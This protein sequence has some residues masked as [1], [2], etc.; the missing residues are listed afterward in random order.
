M[1]EVNILTIQ[2]ILL[3]SFVRNVANHFARFL[4]PRVGAVIFLLDFHL[5]DTFVVGESH[6]VEEHAELVR[7]LRSL[8]GEQNRDVVDFLTLKSGAGDGTEGP[9]GLSL[10]IRLLRDEESAAR[11]VVEPCGLIHLKVS[12]ELLGA[13]QAVH[14][15]LKF[16]PLD[17]LVA[18]H[19][20][21]G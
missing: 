19:D 4:Q 15:V 1:L 21:D 6:R 13:A 9:P 12:H 2:R 17:F 10:L 7:V 5:Q 16:L 3:L 11:I 18:G 20:C 8:F 14:H